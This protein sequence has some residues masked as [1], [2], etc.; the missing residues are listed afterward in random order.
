LAFFDLAQLSPTDF[1]L[2]IWASQLIDVIDQHLYSTSSFYCLKRTL[3]WNVTAT[4]GGSEEKE[5]YGIQSHQNHN[6]RVEMIET[7]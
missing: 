3:W 2:S 5:N 4:D 6:H 7:N 1:K